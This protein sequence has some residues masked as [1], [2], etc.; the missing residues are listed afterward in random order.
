MENIKKNHEN[1]LDNPLNGFKLIKRNSIDLNFYLNFFPD[2]KKRFENESIGFPTENDLSGAISGLLRLQKNYKLKSADLANGNLN[3]RMTGSELTTHDLFVI[4]KFA[5][6]LHENYFAE[7]Y[8]ELAIEKL[9]LKHVDAEVTTLEV[10]ECLFELYLRKFDLKKAN[11]ILINLDLE[12]QIRLMS[13]FRDEYHRARSMKTVEFTNPFD[14]SFVKTGIYDIKK[15]MTIFS[16][17]CRGLITK[18][19][20]ETKTLSCYYRSTNYFTKIAPFK[21]EVVNSD[22]QLLLFY[23]VTS[24]YESDTMKNLLRLSELR[25][26]RIFHENGTEITTDQVRVADLGW[27]TEDDHDIF[28]KL[29]ARLEVRF[30]SIYFLND[31]F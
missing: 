15:E 28:P 19:P 1:Y 17:V 30:N 7:N 14:D 16:Q 9:M 2:I 5:L 12:H 10:S 25:A 31:E 8:L 20:A 24:D 26:A 4:G 22:P 18:S 29:T 6:N 11:L 23:N 21:V 27:Y 13:K 3:G